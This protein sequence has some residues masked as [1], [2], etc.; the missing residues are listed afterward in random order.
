MALEPLD[1]KFEAF[2]WRVLSID[3][4]DLTKSAEAIETAQAEK[5]KAG[6]HYRRHD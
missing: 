5:E 1:K 4:H 6:H 3:G 2:G